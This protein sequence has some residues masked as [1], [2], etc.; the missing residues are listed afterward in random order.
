MS[1]YLI[2]TTKQPQEEAGAIEL[3]VEAAV[4]AT[5]KQFGLKR[6]AES[7]TYASEVREI[8]LPIAA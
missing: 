2:T 7:L 5:V 4:E 1:L 6:F 3:A 8:W